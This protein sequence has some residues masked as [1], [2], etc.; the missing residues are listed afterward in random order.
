[1]SMFCHADAGNV[2]DGRLTWTGNFT[3]S[4]FDREI[5]LYNPYDHNWWLGQFSV[6]GQLTWTLVGNTWKLVGNTGVGFG[7]QTEVCLLFQ[8]NQST[9]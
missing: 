2:Q 7:P 8:G 6:G 5:L 4:G 9:L 3:S 1:M